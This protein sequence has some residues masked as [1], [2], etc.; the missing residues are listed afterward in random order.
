MEACKNPCIQF[1]HEGAC[2]ESMPLFTFLNIGY[3]SWYTHTHLSIHLSLN[4]PTYT[5]FY[6]SICVTICDSPR[7]TYTYTYLPTYSSFLHLSAFL[8]PPTYCTFLRIYCLP[9]YQS[10]HPSTY[11]PIYHLNFL[12]MTMSPGIECGSPCS[13]EVAPVC[14]SN[15]MT[16]PNLCA[17]Q[18]TQCLCPCLKLAHDGACDG[19]YFFCSVY[20]SLYVM[21]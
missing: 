7:P 9:T 16:F 3:F 10:I 8:Y 17:L 6:F 5:I 18:Q 4:L 19:N 2:S 14:G 12:H 13:D 1:L 15:G 21:D 20:V 11:L